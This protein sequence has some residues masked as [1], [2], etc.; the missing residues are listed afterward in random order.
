MG[1][2]RTPLKK[3]GLTRTE[4]ATI[5]DYLDDSTVSLDDKGKPWLDIAE[6]VGITLLQTTHFKPPGL[7]TI[8]PKPIQQACK[9]DE[10]LIN[11]ICEEERELI[12]AQASGRLE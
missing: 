11:A 10:G 1:R 4:T 9:I 3:R 7:R 2:I 8:N 12:G 6:D 5:S